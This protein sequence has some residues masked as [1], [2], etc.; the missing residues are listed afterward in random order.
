MDGVEARD[1]RTLGV[2]IRM[3]RESAGQTQAYVAERAGISRQLLVKIESGHAR[4]ELGKVLRVVK[5]LGIVLV[6]ADPPSF[7][8]APELDLDEYLR[9]F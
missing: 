3:R 2:A 8:S 6:L 4:A 7:Q 1:A 5:A 9:G